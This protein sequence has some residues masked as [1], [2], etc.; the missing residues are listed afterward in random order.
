MTTSKVI[1]TLIFSLVVSTSIGQELANELYLDKKVKSVRNPSGQ[2]SYYDKK[3]K[4]Y[5]EI[6][7]SKT[8]SELYKVTIRYTYNKEGN[9][10][11]VYSKEY[12]KEN[13]TTYW[14]TDIYTYLYNDGKRR[15][16]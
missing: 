1:I 7:N 13:D 5:K 4:L 3:G 15:E 10:E 12:V 6:Y 16:Q 2:T 9:I 14:A 8:P 11:K